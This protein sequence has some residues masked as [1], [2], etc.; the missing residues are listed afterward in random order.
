MKSKTSKIFSLLLLLLVFGAAVSADVKVRFEGKM[1]REVWVL[2]EMPKAMP[3]GGRAFTTEEVAVT[4]SKE[5]ESGVIVAYIPK[6][7][8]VATKKVALIENG[9]WVVE[10]DEWRI[11]QVRIEAFSRGEPIQKGTVLASKGDYS[12]TQPVE[13]GAATFFAVPFGDV[14]FVVKYVSGG[15]DK[16]S[17]P[18]V[19][20]MPVTRD[21]LV[22]TFAITVRDAVDKDVAAAPKP[23]AERSPFVT[24]IAWLIALGIGAGALYFILRAVR[25]N[26]GTVADGLQKLGVQIPG[27]TPTD[28]EAGAEPFEAAPIV[29]EGHCQYCVQAFAEDG[30]C[31]CKIGSPPAAVLSTSPR[32]VGDITI[33]IADGMSVLG[34]EAELQVADPTVSRKHAE[35]ERR[36]GA[37][38]I[39][40]A[41]SA[42]G[43]FVNGQRIEAEAELYPGD[44]VQFGA[45]KFRFE[46]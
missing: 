45:V 17:P 2:A 5:N 8:N 28:D 40:D 23:E 42:N 13:N 14:K 33:E 34:R 26:E 38:F 41:G 43:T 27:A 32:L 12:Q 7:G 30:S 16:A 21:E 9:A 36:E 20:R 22:Q 44:T 1:E 19:F 4:I 3:A 25:S 15:A 46:G 39:R 37:V 35:I 11:G 10:K 18:Q 29:P 31:A 6:S 24:G